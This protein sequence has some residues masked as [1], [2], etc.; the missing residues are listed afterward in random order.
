MNRAEYVEWAAL[1]NYVPRVHAADMG[2]PR[3]LLFGYN[4]AKNS[5]HVYLDGGYIHRLI[6]TWREEIL[7]HREEEEMDIRDMIP[8][9]RVYP[10]STDFEFAKLALGRGIEIP[11]LPWDHNLTITADPF[12]GLRCS[13]C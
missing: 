5:F 7:S 4:S 8:D 1:R 6:Y 3:T 12:K 10:A 13:E 11:F 2:V 9:K